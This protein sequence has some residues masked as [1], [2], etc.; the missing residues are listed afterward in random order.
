MTQRLARAARL[1]EL[2]RRAEQSAQQRVAV[3]RRRELDA[4]SKALEAEQRW[5]DMA[6]R[7]LPPRG[8]VLDLDVLDAHLRTL[9]ARADA[10]ARAA[11]EAAGHHA[12][13]AKAATEAALER[14][15]L[16]LW[17]ER[18][19]ATEAEAAARVEQKAFDELA[20]SGWRGRP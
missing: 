20:S 18:L 2:A 10:G 13:C 12:S 6:S 15:K 9:R 16:E 4:Q 8:G 17:L 14:R 7:P 11:T 19:Q 3:A 1:I 5:A